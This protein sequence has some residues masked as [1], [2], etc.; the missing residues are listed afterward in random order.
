MVDVAKIEAEMKNLGIK[1]TVM[2]EKCG[3]TRPTLNKRLAHPE[4]ITVS[5]AKNM[6]R[7]LR[8]DENSAKFM[9]I[10]FAPDV[11]ENVNKEGR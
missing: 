2:A 10:F 6:A 5:D 4:S 11:E 3:M 8:I 9:E 7:S 1:K